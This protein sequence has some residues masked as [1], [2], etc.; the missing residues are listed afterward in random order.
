M[1]IT[2][3]LPVELHGCEEWS[4]ALREK[5]RLRIFENRIQM[6]IFGLKRD[7]NGECKR[8][9]NEEVHSL[10]SFP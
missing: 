1:E 10:C 6:R 5:R 4:L 2:I 8:L 3:I 9:Q 7:E